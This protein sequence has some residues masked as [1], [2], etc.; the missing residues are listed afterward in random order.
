MPPPPAAAAA[1]A[2][3]TDAT[4]APADVKIQLFVTVVP[5]AATLEDGGKQEQQHKETTT[6]SA[7]AAYSEDAGAVTRSAALGALKK[8]DARLVAFWHG[9]QVDVGAK[10]VEQIGWHTGFGIKVYELPPAPVPAAAGAAAVAEGGGAGQGDDGGAGSDADWARVQSLVA[11]WPPVE[12]AVAARGG[13]VL[14]EVSGD[15]AIKVAQKQARA[16]VAARGRA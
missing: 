6:V 3:A 2:A 12:R 8:Q 11:F 9:E 4:G 15:A 16:L 1:A 13:L 7:H 14:R 5:L 10:T